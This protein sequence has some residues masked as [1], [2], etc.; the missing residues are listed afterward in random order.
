[1]RIRNLRHSTFDRLR[2]STRFLNWL[3]EQAARLEQT[4]RYVYDTLLVAQGL[5]SEQVEAL[6]APEPDPEG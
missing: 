5:T 3:D 2:H 1:M 6:P 4:D